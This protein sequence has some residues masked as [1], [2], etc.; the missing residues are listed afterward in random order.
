MAKSNDLCRIKNDESPLVEQSEETTMLQQIQTPKRT[1][2]CQIEKRGGELYLIYVHSKDWKRETF[3]H[4]STRDELKS[5]VNYY[6][7]E[8]N[9][10]NTKVFRELYPEGFENGEFWTIRDLIVD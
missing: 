10:P 5:Y 1:V 3:Y 4:V 2:K 6:N 9:Y 7:S 8:K